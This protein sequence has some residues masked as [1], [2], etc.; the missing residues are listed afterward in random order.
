MKQ[1]TIFQINKQEG[2][3]LKY[4]KDSKT[5]I[6][7]S[8]DLDDIYRIIEKYNL[9]KEHKILILLDDMIKDMLSNKKLIQ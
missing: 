4:C 2:I 6:E 9:H 5:F 8:N 1:N 7:Y 3:G